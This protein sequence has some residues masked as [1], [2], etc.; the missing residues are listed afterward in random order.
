MQKTWDQY[1]IQWGFE[2]KVHPPTIK[3]HEKVAK[4]GKVMSS[5]VSQTVTSN[6]RKRKFCVKTPNEPMEAPPTTEQEDERFS[7]ILG[8]GKNHFPFT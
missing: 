1:L 4:P 7:R 6:K 8:G 3:S 2:K 5:S